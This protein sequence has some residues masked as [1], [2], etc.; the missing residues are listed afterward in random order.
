MTMPHFHSAFRLGHPDKATKKVQYLVKMIYSANWFRNDE[1]EYSELLDVATDWKYSVHVDTGQMVPHYSQPDGKSLIV[2][3]HVDACQ[4]HDLTSHWQI[5]WW[6]FYFIN[7]TSMNWWSNTFHIIAAATNGAASVA[8]RTSF[9]F[10]G[11]KNLSV[12]LWCLYQTKELHE[13]WQQ[14]CYQEV[15]HLGTTDQ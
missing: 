15:K 8:A 6:P 12:I 9:E 7:D 1:P 13:W 11:S 5:C 14:V 3:D 2:M 10:S 4:F